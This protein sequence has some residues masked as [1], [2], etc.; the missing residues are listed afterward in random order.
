M[1]IN[2]NSVVYMKEYLQYA[3]EFEKYVYIWS[4]AMDEVNR[5]MRQI[6]SEKKRIEN[7][8]TST[9]KSLA[10]LEDA[11]E[12]Q[13]KY[14]EQEMLR[15]KKK[16]RKA[17]VTMLVILFVLFIVGSVMGLVI[18]SEPNVTFVVPEDIFVLVMGLAVMVIGAVAVVPAC[19]GN[20]FSCKKKAKECANEEK[21]L[22][23][24][25]S[26][27]RRKLLLQE[28]E[29]E[30]ENDWVVNE[31]E[32]AIIGQRQEEIQAALQEAK[33]NLNRIYSENILPIKYRSLKAVST[34]Y[35][36]LVTGRCNTIQGH[37]G[38][39]DTYEVEKIH[40]AQLEEMMKMN[41][42]LNRIEDNQRYICQELRQANYTLSCISSSLNEI[43]RTNEEIARSTAISAEANKQMAAATRWMAWNAW[44]NGY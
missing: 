38:I 17:L 10:T 43:E 26:C 30:V 22:A 31:I 37:G 40:I 1:A 39:Y 33:I 9:K 15:Y 34:L 2:K 11:N 42:T 36:Y 41:A 29:S 20:Y 27:R 7:T 18:A 5:R 21:E 32:E 35:E 14:K 25:S 24:Q 8:R 16:A 19:L 6:Y 23:T 12:R 3:V 28:K 44:A 4:K 13:R